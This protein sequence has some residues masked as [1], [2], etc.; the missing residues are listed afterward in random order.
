LS[1]RELLTIL[2]AELERLPENYRWPLVLCCLEGLSQE[3][4]ARHLG[5]SPAAVRGRLERGRQCLRQRLAARGLTLSA[6]LAVVLVGRVAEAV[7]PALHETTLQAAIAGTGASPA[8]TALMREALHMMLLGKMKVVGAGVLLLGV[9]AASA[10]LLQ[11]GFANGDDRGNPTLPAPPEPARAKVDLHGDPLPEGA[12]MRLGTLKQRAGAKLAFAPPMA[13][14]SSAFAA[15]VR[16]HLG[17]RH[18]QTASDARTAGRALTTSA[19]SPDGRWL[20]TDNAARDGELQIWD[21]QTGKR[22]HTLMIQGARYLMPMAFSP[23]GKH[24]AAV[25]NARMKFVRV[26]RLEDGKQVFAT[27]IPTDVSSDKLAFTPDGKRLLASFGS[28]ID[29]GMRCWELA[30]GELVWQNKE[31]APPSFAFTADGKMVSAGDHSS[32]SSI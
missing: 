18:G 26:W 32:A 24:V 6:T 12:V 20:A 19:V 11:R 25:G 5:C 14:R 13:R 31:Y 2:D 3:E 22:A 9:L 17:R 28:I 8:V 21:V 29:Q 23:D 7:P 1:T 16:Q 27:D 15:E 4:A 30:S 10:L